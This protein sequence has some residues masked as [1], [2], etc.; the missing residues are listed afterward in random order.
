V[1]QR[2]DI[3]EDFDLAFCLKRHGVIK[4]D[5]RL[6]VKTSFR[7]VHNSL[8]GQVMFHV[9]SIRTFYLRA[10]VI[11]T[12]LFVISRITIVLVGLI[13]IFD[14]YILQ[15]IMRSRGHNFDTPE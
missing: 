15:P 2:P 5:K 8:I 1:M 10:G 6:I 9:R 3:W 4:Q 13:V 12:L 14:L 7:A 11:K